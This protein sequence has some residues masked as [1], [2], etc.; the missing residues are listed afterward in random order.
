MSYD[1]SMNILLLG[2]DETS[3]TL[4]EYYGQYT[5]F[6]NHAA[7]LSTQ[8][9]KFEWTLLNDLYIEVGDGKFVIKDSKTSTH[10]YEYDLILI[11]GKGLADQFD[12]VKA[13]SVYGKL[14]GISIVN[15]YK[16]FRNS[17]KLVQAVQFHETGLPVASTVYVNRSLV[18]N[19]FAVPFGFPCIMKAS[20]GSHGNDNYLIHSAEEMIHII[21]KPNSPRFVLQRHIPN[22]ND[23]RVLVCGDRTLIISRKGVEG[24]HLNNTSQGGEAFM[25]DEHKL[26]YGMVEQAKK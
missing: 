20:F 9:I 17:S 4:D 18:E 5:D 25:I 8:A 22:E 3:D 2:S 7:S 21:N 6:F 10:L 1:I 15:D 11:R 14:N 23:F 26:P 16:N 12:V 24:T 13:V 19:K